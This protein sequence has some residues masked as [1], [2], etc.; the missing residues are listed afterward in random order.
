[1][2]SKCSHTYANYFGSHRSK[3]RSESRAAG[4]VGATSLK[5][6]REVDVSR[7]DPDRAEE[8]R[9]KIVQVAGQQHVRSSDRCGRMDTII[10][11]GKLRPRQ[12]PVLGGVDL[13]VIEEL[14]NGP[15]HRL[16]RSRIA[17]LF[18]D[19]HSFPLIEQLDGPH[20]IR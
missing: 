8:V 13:G 11:V 12:V 17:P 1:M 14:A 7:G 2:F 19:D 6:F 4:T 20:K 9:W 15:S 10:W 3:R 16:S 5:Q 18:A